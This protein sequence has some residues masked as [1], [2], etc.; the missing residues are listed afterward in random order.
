MTAGRDTLITSS[1]MT[2]KATRTESGIMSLED[3]EGCAVGR[4]GN[5]GIGS[6]D[7]HNRYVILIVQSQECKCNCLH[8]L[9]NVAQYQNTY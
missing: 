3:C 2:E 5:W 4:A 7:I 9:F 6:N 8:V 1:R